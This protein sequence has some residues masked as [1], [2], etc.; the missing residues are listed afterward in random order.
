VPGKAVAG[1]DSVSVTEVLCPGPRLTEE[2][3]KT[4]CHPAGC[5]EDKLNMLDEQPELSP[6][7]TATV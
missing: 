1:T 4:P 2:E 6:F 5:V 7:E 3:E